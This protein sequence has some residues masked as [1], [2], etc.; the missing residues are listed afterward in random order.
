MV[1]GFTRSAPPGGRWECQSARRAGPAIER[2]GV[3]AG[4]CDG[5]GEPSRETRMQHRR[6]RRR[7]GVGKAASATPSKN[8][9]VISTHQK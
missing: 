6:E 4:A 5:E 9:R 2:D 3:A 1:A 8:E 7:R